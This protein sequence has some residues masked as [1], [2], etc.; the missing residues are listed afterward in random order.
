M[1]N[2]GL[3]T[4]GGTVQAGEGIYIPRLADQELLQLCRERV[5]A[6][7]L[8]PRQMGKSSLMV[9]TAE[10]LQAEGVRTA[11]VDLQD[12]GAQVTAEQWYFGF[13]VKL[14]DQ[15]ELET[16]VVSWWQGRSHLGVSQRLT[17][18]FEQVLLREIAEPVVIFVDEIDSTL[19]LDFTDDFF[20]AIRSLYMVRA[21]K[22]KF[23]R[24]SFVLLGVAAPGDLIRDPQRTP[25]NIGQRVDLKG[26][27]LHEAKSLATGL[28]DKIDNPL[29]ALE[30]ILNW[31]GGQPFL[32][33]KICKLL[34]TV[35]TVAMNDET[36]WVNHL[37]QSHIIDNWEV[38]DEPEH[39][40]TIRTR[41]LHDKQLAWQLLV[42]YRQI[43]Q[44]REITTD[45]SSEK[46]KLKLSGLVV[47]WHGKLSV[48]NRI[49]EAIFDHSWIERELFN[50]QP[51]SQIRLIFEEI[52]HALREGRRLKDVDSRDPYY[53]NQFPYVWMQQYPWRSGE[54][55]IPEHLNL[56]LEEKQQIEKQLLNDLPSAQLINSSQ[57]MKLIELQHI[58][59]QKYI[60]QGQKQTLSSDV[61]EY[62][63]HRLIVS[64]TVRQ[65]KCS[66]DLTYYVLAR[67][68]Y[69]PS[70]DKERLYIMVDEAAQ[71]FWMLKNW[72]ERQ[73]N[74]LRIAEWLDIS[75]EH[76]QQAFEELD[77]VVRVWAN[78]YHQD[79]GTRIVL[80]AMLGLLEHE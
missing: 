76:F 4:V 7:V 3:Y 25:F 23:Q 40:K 45:I 46:M 67:E 59:A 68:S 47:E 77:E 14:E 65:I 78:K 41:L 50:L 80:Q 32:T 22:S 17:M 36:E 43:L 34:L 70:D 61:A 5:F 19:S 18:F 29:V 51:D 54:S 9:Q 6:Y 37:V 20:I 31:T 49:Y 55:R 33:Q 44:R 53:L 13:L 8:T 52:S 69:S 79:G 11:I 16:D 62:V 56:T 73:P 71:Y 74:S 66:H 72:Q 39:L 57:L 26:F 27:Q 35:D 42:L 10:R 64:G 63:K 75:P 2:P 58:E 30:A 24:L 1:A 28:A 48:H 21:Q 60:S 38:H 15:L 12:L